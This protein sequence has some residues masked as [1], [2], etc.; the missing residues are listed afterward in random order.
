MLLMMVLI[1]GEQYRGRAGGVGQAADVRDNGEVQ[2]ARA[3]PPGRR[4]HAERGPRLHTEGDIGDAGAPQAAAR[5]SGA[6]AERDRADGEGER[7]ESHRADGPG[8]HRQAAHGQLEA[9]EVER[10]PVP[11][12][13][14]ARRAGRRQDRGAEPGAARAENIGDGA[15]DRGGEDNQAQRHRQRVREG[16][17]QAHGPQVT[18]YVCIQL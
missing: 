8:G 1:S 10:A 13:G 7:A 9:E 18:L 5:A 12:A 16:S 2:T 4:G 11:V 15:T 17:G 3:H 14:V 6:P